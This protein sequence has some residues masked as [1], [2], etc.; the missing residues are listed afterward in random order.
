MPGD[1]K[2]AGLPLK[3]QGTAPPAPIY[4]RRPAAAPSDPAAVAKSNAPQ[5]NK[6]AVDSRADPSLACTTSTHPLPDGYGTQRS[7]LPRASEQPAPVVH[8]ALVSPRPQ[9]ARA[10]M[11]K[12]NATTKPKGP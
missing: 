5:K 4:L 1:S 12:A 7:D 3:S 9:T 8:P 10:E 6:A 11:A 2:K